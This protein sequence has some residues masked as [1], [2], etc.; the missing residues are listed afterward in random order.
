MQTP[1]PPPNSTEG[2]IYSVGYNAWGA[3]GLSRMM[4]AL[5]AEG[6]TILV[7]TRNSDYRARH[8]FD[9]L[10][11]ATR[12]GQRIALLCACKDV[13]TCHRSRWLGDSLA[14]RGVDVGHIEPGEYDH[15]RAVEQGEREL[16]TITPHSELPPLP[17]YSDV[18][19]AERQAYWRERSKQKPPTDYQSP[20][21]KRA[22]PAEPRQVLIAGS[23]NANNAQLNYA[24][25]LVERA[26][27]VR[28]QQG[29]AA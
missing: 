5:E 19:W 20:E 29:R 27:N 15:E 23:M 25:A 16:Y 22:I 10:A 28:A 21:P 9:Q 11:E 26:A 1:V 24:S 12:K 13:H 14:R 8:S 17:D 4:D 18:N 7:D 3:D 2:G 6:V